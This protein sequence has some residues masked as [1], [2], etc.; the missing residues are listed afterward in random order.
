MTQCAAAGKINASVGGSKTYHYKPISTDDL[1]LA[2]QTALTNFGDVKGQN[3]LVNGEHEHTLNEIL[4]LLESAVGKGTGQTSLSKSFLRLNLSDFVEEF[5][6]GITHDKNFRNFAEYFDTHK[7]NLL[8]GSTDFFQ[9]HGLK[10]TK[11]LSD[12]YKGV[13]IHEE[14]LVFPIFSN[15]KMTSLD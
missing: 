6:T 9:K 11:D 2:V 12:S 10:H 5:F 15:Y 8:E 14:D 3:Y 13:N 1:A 7:P 4:H